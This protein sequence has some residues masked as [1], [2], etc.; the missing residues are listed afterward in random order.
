MTLLV[1]FALALLLCIVMKDQIQMPWWGLIFASGIALTF[2]LPVSIIT[3]TTNQVV[4]KKLLIK[5]FLLLF[6]S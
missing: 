4:F 1:S 3:A 2:T 5:P 6:L